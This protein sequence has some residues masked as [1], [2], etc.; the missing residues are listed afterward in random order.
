MAHVAPALVA[1]TGTLASGVVTVAGAVTNYRTFATALADGDTVDVVIKDA[2]GDQASYPASI[3]DE[4]AGT[5]TL[6]SVDVSTGTI[7]DGAVTVWAATDAPELSKDTTPQLGGNLD[8]QGYAL[9]D[10]TET[11]NTE[12]TTGNITLNL[13]DGMVQRITL[14]DARQITMPADP[15]AFGQTFTLFVDCASYTPTW[16]TAPA[17]LWLTSDQAAPT[18]ETTSGAVNVLVFTWDDG[19]NSGAGAWFGQYAGYAEAP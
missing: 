14:D 6:G 16:N 3:W 2:Q 5:L 11:L 1:E 19:Y 7:T 4:T 12:T 9:G 17:I 8:A 15:G 18:L 10:Y 13:A